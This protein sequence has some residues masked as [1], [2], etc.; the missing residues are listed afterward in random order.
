MSVV[1][2]KREIKRLT[3]IG[4]KENL[5]GVHV[6][7]KERNAIETVSIVWK[8]CRF[9]EKKTSK[10]DAGNARSWSDPEITDSITEISEFMQLKEPVSYYQ[11]NIRFLEPIL[12]N[13]KLPH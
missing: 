4:I 12:S 2:W 11:H 5:K 1:P 8:I 3:S 9:L 13:S 7:S 10:N 6:V